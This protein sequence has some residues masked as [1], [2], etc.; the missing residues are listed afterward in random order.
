MK[1]GWILVIVA[2][3]AWSCEQKGASAEPLVSTEK[4]QDSANASQGAVEVK[5]G[6]VRTVPVNASNDVAAHASGSKPALNPAHGEPY[7]RCDIEVGA[8]IDSQPKT[9][10]PAMTQQNVSSSNFDTN[11]IPATVQPSASS[12]NL[13]PKPALNPPHGEPHHRCDLQVGAPLT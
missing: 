11:P 12:Q 6:E 1:K 5:A 13:G 7:H 4:I 2:T 9:V 10:A 3:I 8:P